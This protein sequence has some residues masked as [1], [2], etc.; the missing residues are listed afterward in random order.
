MESSNSQWQIENLL[1][2]RLER[3][4]ERTTALELA[5]GG[6]FF[7]GAK[8]LLVAMKLKWRL[9]EAAGRN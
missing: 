8:L 7:A 2:T 1:E 4:I 5:E 3:L 9:T 6:N